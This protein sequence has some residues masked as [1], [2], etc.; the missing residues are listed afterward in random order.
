MM[1]FC[2][3]TKDWTMGLELDKMA[4][5]PEFFTFHLER[6]GTG[7]VRIQNVPEKR[8][9]DLIWTCLPFGSAS[10]ADGKSLINFI[11]RFRKPTGNPRETGVLLSGFARAVSPD[12]H[13]FEGRLFV[14]PLDS[15]V[16]AAGN[17]ELM[18]LAPDPGD[19]GTGTGS[20]T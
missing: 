11:F 14:F 12:S 1:E 5:K 17:E 20:Q 16:P 9:S 6:G 18:T 19:T 13:E 2:D 10:Q 7:Q 8:M 3:P 15:T 4:G